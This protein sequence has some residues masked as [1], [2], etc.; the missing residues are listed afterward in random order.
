MMAMGAGHLEV[1]RLL[2]DSGANVHAKDENGMTAL[3]WAEQYGHTEVSE[4]LRR[5]GAAD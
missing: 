3:Y 1:V 2:L 4:L 5:A